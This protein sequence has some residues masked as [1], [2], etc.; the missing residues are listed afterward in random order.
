MDK[1]TLAFVRKWHLPAL[2]GIAI[3][4]MLIALVW[5]SRREVPSSA[6][7]ELFANSPSRAVPA[8]P[9]VSAQIRSLVPQ[10]GQIELC[11]YGRVQVVDGIPQFPPGLESAG[12]LALGRLAAVLVGRPSEHDRALGL[13][14]SGGLHEL[15]RL[16]INSSDP[17]LYALAIHSCRSRIGDGAEGDCSQLNFGQWARIEPGNAAPWLGIAN[18]ALL[19]GDKA[20]VHDAMFRASR[21]RFSDFHDDQ[22]Y[23]LIASDLM[24]QQEKSDQ[25]GIM[26][27]VLGIKAAVA[28]PGLMIP[29]QY[30]S[31]TTSIDQYRLQVCGD[32]A[33]ML[34][35]NGRSLMDVG[36]GA[37]TASRMGW[38]D[39]RLSALHD[40]VDALHQVEMDYIA[41]PEESGDG[42]FS[43]DGQKIFRRDAA[44]IAKV[45]EAAKFRLALKL[46]G[47]P[48]PQLAERWRAKHPEVPR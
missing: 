46:G 4:A 29:Y 34:I 16:A 47:I 41:R 1:T 22:I 7:S 13:S 38:T 25:T 8:R 21:S 9:G 37:A 36:I 12:Q 23:E 28:L 18:E 10:A 30:C 5:W 42:W 17:D 14:L 26:M 45:G 3:I 48:I 11:G 33:A 2:G 43:C 44:V 20:T 32:L 35:R 15:V 39:A 31:S 19:H 6:P 24:T 40:E 27:S